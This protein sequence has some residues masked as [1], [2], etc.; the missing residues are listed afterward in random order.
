MLID[1]DLKIYKTLFI[2]CSLLMS[3][4]VLATPT[5]PLIKREA[6]LKALSH[7]QGRSDG[8][9]YLLSQPTGHLRAL[10]DRSLLRE[11]AQIACQPLKSS[12]D[13]GELYENSWAA[14]RILGRIQQHH[15]CFSQLWILNAKKTKNLNTYFGLAPL[16]L[17][18]REV[19]K[20]LS[21]QGRVDLLNGS[22][23]HPDPEVR[24]L[25]ARS[26]V[27]PELLCT[28]TKDPW[29]I[30]KKAVI[31]GLESIRG[32]LATCMVDLL[33]DPD[34]YIVERA[35]TALG[36]LSSASWAREMSSPPL[37]LIEG[38]STL[39]HDRERGINERSAALRALSRWGNT[40]IAEEFW[41]AHLESGGLI[42]LAK[43]ALEAR[44]LSESSNPLA[45]IREAIL[46]SRSGRI[47]LSG[48]V[49]LI[50]QRVAWEKR[51]LSKKDR[52]AFLDQM[53]KELGSSADELLLLRLQQVR[54]QLGNELI[55]E[56]LPDLAPS[57]EDEVDE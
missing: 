3:D 10:V 26:G 19:V 9:R 5:A 44:V 46:S 38:L 23:E 32:P 12:E 28:L 13:Q 21:E 27:D 11:L 7:K 24:A 45:L 16:D 39:A 25:A 56:S 1:F 55:G 8:L 17:L 54:S 37:K 50:D 36:R 18:V 40:N 53:V 22:L 47:K 31:L 20:T 29:A 14:V 35:A 6:T 41:R 49:L 33:E 2:V 57:I 30:V 4:F 48:F 34:S 51:H 43:S 15:E 42:D 52:R